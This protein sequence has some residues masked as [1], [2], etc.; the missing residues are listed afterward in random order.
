MCEG[1][2]TYNISSSFS[3]QVLTQLSSGP[4]PLERRSLQESILQQ[5]FLQLDLGHYDVMTML[6]LCTPPSPRHGVRSLR[7]TLCTGAPPPGETLDL[8]P[9]LGA[10]SLVGQVVIRGQRIIIED[11]QRSVMVPLPRRAGHRSMAIYP[12]QWASGIAG[13][14]TVASCRPSAFSPLHLQLLEQY[15]ELLACT[16]EDKTFYIPGQMA[17]INMPPISVQEPYLS[18]FRARVKT[19]CQQK[20]GQHHPITEAQAEVLVWQQIEEE[21][22]W[23]AM[24]EERSS[25]PVVQKAARSHSIPPSISE[26]KPISSVPTALTPLIGREKEHV[27]LAHMLVQPEIRLLT[28]TGPG[29]IGKTRLALEVAH[30]LQGEWTHG[31]CFVDLIATRTTDQVIHTLAQALGKEVG[32]RPLIEVIQDFL[33]DKSLLLVLD[34]FE[35]VLCAAPSLT[36]LLT[37]C[38]GVTLLVTSRARLRIGGEHEFPVPPLSLPDIEREETLEELAGSPAVALFLRRVQAITP[39]FPRIAQRDCLATENDVRFSGHWDVLLYSQ[40]RRLL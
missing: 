19:L 28:L 6:A 1:E 31:A 37:C 4:S 25:F 11:S 39:N 10:E 5:A 35:Q 15:A 17:L 16:C 24:G 9:Y 14:F 33:R 34:N 23:L 40:K 13:T 12:L 29:G 2:H 26:S 18:Y 27:S 3:T 30:D 22:S 21:L 36:S 20:E 32:Q 8:K 38:P 7:G